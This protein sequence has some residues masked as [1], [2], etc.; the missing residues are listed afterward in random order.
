MRKGQIKKK[1]FIF[2]K[3]ILDL[4]KVKKLLKIKIFQDNGYGKDIKLMY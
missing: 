2:Q 1:I 3:I 4:L